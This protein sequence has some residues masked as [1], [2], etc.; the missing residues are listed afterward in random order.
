[1]S[2][3]LHKTRNMPC[4]ITIWIMMQTY[5]CFFRVNYRFFLNGLLLKNCNFASQFLLLLFSL[6]DIPLKSFK[7]PATLV[8]SIETICNLVS[9]S[10]KKY[11]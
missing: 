2:R 4:H 10:Y 3:F 5:A 7:I 8:T 9:L 6:F 1:M 11:V